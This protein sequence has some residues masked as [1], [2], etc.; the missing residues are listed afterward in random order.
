MKN[1]NKCKVQNIKNI[2]KGIQ[3]V[4]EL[5]DEAEFAIGYAAG[6]GMSDFDIL[7]GDTL[8]I[9]TSAEIKNG[10]IIMVHTPDH[11]A[12]IRQILIDEENEIFILH[13]A[14][15]EKRED[16]CTESPEI[17]GVV[18]HVLRKRKRPQ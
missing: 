2:N 13:A 12:I 7:D 11:V 17:T 3:F 14:G 9:S 10:D 5:I 15:I 8:F 18:T 4:F 6:N 1:L 16:I